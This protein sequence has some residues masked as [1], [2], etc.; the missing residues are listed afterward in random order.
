MKSVKR[1]QDV[2]ILS[3]DEKF[4]KAEAATQQTLNILRGAVEALRVDLDQA[5][6]QCKQA[7]EAMLQA[8]SEQ[9]QAH[10]LAS[11]NVTSY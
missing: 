9:T 11:Y 1:A 5:W 7:Q 10:T 4:N 3:L 2:Q 6:S 8:T